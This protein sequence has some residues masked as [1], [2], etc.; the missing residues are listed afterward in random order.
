[1]KLL[2]PKIFTASTINLKIVRVIMIPIITTQLTCTIVP[3]DANNRILHNFLEY[4]GGHTPHAILIFVTNSIYR[5]RG[6][7]LSCIF[8]THPLFFDRN[9]NRSGEKMNRF[10]C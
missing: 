9:N 8:F 2:K 1:M 6:I 5:P 10:E 3:T 7:K 4:Y